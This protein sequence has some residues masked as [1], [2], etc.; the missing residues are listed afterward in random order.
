M[1]KTRTVNGVSPMSLFAARFAAGVNIF[2]GGAQSRAQYAVTSDGRFLVNMQ[3]DDPA[4][5]INVILNWQ[6]ALR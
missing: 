3:V 5:P 2:A 4:S 1:T 6:A